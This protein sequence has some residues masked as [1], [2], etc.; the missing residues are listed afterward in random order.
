MIFGLLVPG[1]ATLRSEQREE[2]LIPWRRRGK[3]VFEEAASN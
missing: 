3:L 2:V 1:A